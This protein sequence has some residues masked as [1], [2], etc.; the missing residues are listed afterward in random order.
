MARVRPY[1]LEVVKRFLAP[2]S[3]RMK[4]YYKTEIWHHTY[5]EKVV[6]AMYEF[7]KVIAYLIFKI[8]KE[9]RITNID[10]L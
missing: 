1:D 9:S 2:L 5:A 7:K 3:Q 10:L 8:I 4:Q 6:I